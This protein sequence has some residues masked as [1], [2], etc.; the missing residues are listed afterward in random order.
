MGSIK[1]MY[2]YTDGSCLRNKK[3]GWAFIVVEQGH[4]TWEQSGH[5]HHTTN[6]EME[7]EAMHQALL[8]ASVPAILYSDSQYVVKGLNTWCKDWATRGF[9]STGRGAPLHHAALWQAMYPLSAPHVIQWVK[10]HNGH[11]FNEHVDRLAVQAARGAGADA[12]A[13]APTSIPKE[14]GL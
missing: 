13:R 9:T 6:Q 3:G 12:A 1:Q 14:S 10:A 5:K 8:Y 7:L 2:I 4:V 11:V